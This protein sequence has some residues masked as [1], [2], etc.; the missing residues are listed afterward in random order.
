MSVDSKSRS[1]RVALVVDDEIANCWQLTR[2]LGQRFDAVL[3]ATTVAGA[4][5]QLATREVTHLICDQELGADSATGA[6]LIPKWRRRFPALR[7]AV[8]FTG[9]RVEP[10]ELPPEVDAVVS[11][12]DPFPALF[13]ELA[14]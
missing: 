1:S 4:E 13:D 3:S 9:A 2:L 5:R 7:C 6:E 12:D 14:D 11:K 8:L 10:A